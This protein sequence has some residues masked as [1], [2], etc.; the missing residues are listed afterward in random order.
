VASK[1]YR[2]FLNELF[3]LPIVNAPTMDQ[4]RRSFEEVMSHYPPDPEVRFADFSIGQIG[5][6]WALA[7]GVKKEKI[8]LFF[9]GGG[10]SAGSVHSHKG[11]MSR[12]AKS[13]EAAVLGF[14]YRL[15]PEHPFPAALEDALTVYRW[16]IHHPY[17]HNH[18]AFVGVS[19]GGGLLLS[20]LQ[21]LK[22]EHMPLPAGG[23]C[24]CPWVDLTDRKYADR[25]DLL[26]PTRLAQASAM[27]RMERSAEDPLISPL[28]GK[29]EGMPPILIQ[30]GTRD[31]LHEE[32][33]EL[34]KKLENSTLES[35]PEMI[36][37]WHLFAGRFP[38][39]KEGID[40]LSKF[41]KN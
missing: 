13:A 22:L 2:E 21:R 12:I 10:Y 31:L 41:L 28:Y 33:V 1:E 38:E 24:I 16:L 39:A 25:R 9:F 4:V 20:L 26:N 34:S 32:A 6:S 27:Y 3:S 19:A 36:H 23:V 35:W 7:P 5:A 8:I 37:C 14:E 30:T 40:R 15:A 18:I 17:P 11:I 29:L